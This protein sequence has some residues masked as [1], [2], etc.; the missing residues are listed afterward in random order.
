MTEP[1]SLGAVVD[2]DELQTIKTVSSDSEVTQLRLIVAEMKGMLTT[3]LANLS[4]DMT[5]IKNTLTSVQ[6]NQ[7]SISTDQATMKQQIINLEHDVKEM[8]SNQD[9]DI[10]LL[11]TRNEN[12]ASRL[13]TT[14][15]MPIIAV[16]ALIT[17]A[18]ALFSHH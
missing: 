15:I 8:K 6:S 3:A 13:T 7:Q 14:Y 11:K 10:K 2:S 17:S 18:I 4:S 12:A 5:G 1:I 9:N 16:L